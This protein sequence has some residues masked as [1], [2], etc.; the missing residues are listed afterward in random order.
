MKTLHFKIYFLSFLILLSGCSNN[1][2][3]ID[4]SDI[5]VTLTIKR[6]E[7]DLWTINTPDLT[8]ENIGLRLEVVKN[9]YGYFYY[10]WIQQPE[11]MGFGKADEPETNEYIYRY[12]KSNSLN[13]MMKLVNEKYGDFSKFEKELAQ[14]YKHFKYYFP[15]EPIPDIVTYISNF[16][17]TMNPVGLD[18]IGIA[19]DMHMG[20]TFFV[21]SLVSPPIE[22]YLLKLFVPETISVM[23]LLAHG[24]DLFIHTHRDQKFCDEMIFWGK[25]MY[26]LQKML[27]DKAPHYLIGMSPEEFK[28]CQ[29]E[30]KE[31]WTYFVSEELLYSPNKKDYFRFFIEAPFTSA[32]GVPPNTPPLLGKYIGWQVVKAYMAKHPELS[33]E[34]LMNKTDAEEILREAKYKP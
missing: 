3:K 26:F 30:E 12:L 27:P 34:Y 9:K 18:Y 21:Y 6:F 13:E 20:D 17:I 22:S 2:D 29:K 11:L 15:N 32:S 7:Q 10:D 4:V 25:M 8:V 14:A 5:D 31:I 19:L 16:S 24:R 28:A 33:L 1:P 23:H